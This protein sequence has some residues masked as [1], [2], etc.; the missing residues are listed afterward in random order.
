ML[1]LYHVVFRLLRRTSTMVVLSMLLLYMLRC[2]VPM[3]DVLTMKLFC[4]LMRCILFIVVDVAVV[5]AMLG[6][7][8][9]VLVYVAVVIVVDVAVVEAMLGDVAVVE[10]MVGDVVFV[11]VYV[12]VIIG[13]CSNCFYYLYLCCGCLNSVPCTAVSAAVYDG[14]ATAAVHSLQVICPQTQSENKCITLNNYIKTF[15]HFTF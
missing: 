7:V 14:Y 13:W 12:A 15:F 8:V 3:V 10:A 5:H 11:L 9:V 1:L 2:A 4:V 6:D